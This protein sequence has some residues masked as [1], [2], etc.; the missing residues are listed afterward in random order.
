ME[1]KNF[2]DENENIED[3][4][5][6][7]N[8]KSIEMASPT[9]DKVLL[10][11]RKDCVMI[12]SQAPDS[13]TGD[14]YNIREINTNPDEHKE[15]DTFQ[16]TMWPIDQTRQRYHKKMTDCVLSECQDVNKILLG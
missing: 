7:S 1:K 3:T 15:G 10:E 4:P 16:L 5:C 14:I 2:K 9:S 6:P 8:Q 13:L 11:R 12:K